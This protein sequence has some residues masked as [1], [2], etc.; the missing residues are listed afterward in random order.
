G[1]ALVDRC[2]VSCPDARRASDA[3]VLET[4]PTT[5]VG[6][7]VRSADAT[8]APQHRRIALVRSRDAAPRHAI[9]SIP[10]R[11][12]SAETPPA[13]RPLA[14]GC[15]CDDKDAQVSNAARGTQD[16]VTRPSRPRE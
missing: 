8:A 10:A 15:Q 9:I 6:R 13:P 2:V 4:R 12:A 11:R 5:A 3:P 7:V 1:A 16:R 14:L